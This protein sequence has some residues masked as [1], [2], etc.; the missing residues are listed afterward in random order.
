MSATFKTSNTAEFT[1]ALNYAKARAIRE[2]LQID[3]VD[4]VGIG[5]A[6]AKIDFD[7]DLLVQVLFEIVEPQ[8]KARSITQEQFWEGFTSG[9]V[10]ESARNALVE[11]AVNFSNPLTRDEL[12]KAIENQTTQIKAMVAS[13]VESAST[14]G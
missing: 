9:E 5:Q 10:F 14:G 8:C 2:S 3:F 13:K 7:T 4:F 1:L 6:F 12:R 11:C